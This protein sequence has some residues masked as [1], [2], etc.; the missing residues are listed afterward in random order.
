MRLDDLPI[1]AFLVRNTRDP[2]GQ[3]GSVREFETH[4]RNHPGHRPFFVAAHIIDLDPRKVLRAPRRCNR[5][6]AFNPLI[7]I[8]ANHEDVVAHRVRLHKPLGVCAREQFAS[9][10]LEP[11]RALH[12]I[13][14][15]TETAI[16]TPFSS[17]ARPVWA[18]WGRTGCYPSN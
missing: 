16:V 18:N 17:A 12:S 3:L 13:S 10:G 11:R 4:L 6:S 14:F 15:R 1:C 5:I 2:C 9:P 7:L 8:S